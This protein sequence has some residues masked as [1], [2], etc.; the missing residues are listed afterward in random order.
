M[1]EILLRKFLQEKGWSLEKL[2]G[3]LGVSYMTAYRWT[4]GKTKPSRL[5]RE[6]IKKKL[7]IE[8]K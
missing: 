7:R 6:I 8:L 3:E 2:A 1:T 5:A 4:K